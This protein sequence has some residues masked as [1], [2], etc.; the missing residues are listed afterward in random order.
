M[1]KSHHF[2]ELPSGEFGHMCNF[3]E[4]FYPPPPLWFKLIEFWMK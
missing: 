4:I 3:V 1:L 2:K